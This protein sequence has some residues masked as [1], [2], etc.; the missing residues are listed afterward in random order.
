MEIAIANLVHTKA[1]KVA[2]VI[3]AVVIL[4]LVV[5]YHRGKGQTSCSGSIFRGCLDPLQDANLGRITLASSHNRAMDPEG[6]SV[7]VDA[8]R[9]GYDATRS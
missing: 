2:I 6:D 7:S 9:S 5:A 3:I 8:P 4:T 1:D